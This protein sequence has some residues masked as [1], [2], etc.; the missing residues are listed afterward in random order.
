[1]LENN[2]KDKDDDKLTDYREQ[3]AELNEQIRQYAKNLAK[4]LYGIDISGWAN[5]LGESLVTAFENG[6][7]AAEAFHKT[8]NDILKDIVKNMVVQD[9]IK[10]KL[11]ALETTLFGKDGEGNGILSNINNPQEA[12]NK[13]LPIINKALNGLENE[14]P[15]IQAFLS[16]IDNQ[17]GG[18]LTSYSEGSSSMTI[19]AKGLTE[20]TGDL[21][22]SYVNAIRADVS[23][24]RGYMQTLVEIS[25]PKMSVIAESQL[26]QLG[27]I[28]EQTKLIENNTRSN[29]ETAQEIKN[30]LSSVVVFTGGGKAIRIKQ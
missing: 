29:A 5:K 11:V 24:N 23:I 1:M 6:E 19:S 12:I 7:N 9:W 15:A 25:I 3:I 27:Q 26:K 10:P 8:V 22:A 30:T 2:K 28:L 18:A 14:V 17:L 13:A 21:L 16:A 4:E 20:E